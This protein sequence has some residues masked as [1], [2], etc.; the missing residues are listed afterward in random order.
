LV[1]F[2]ALLAFFVGVVFLATA[3][4]FAVVVVG[5]FLAGAEAA[6]FGVVAFAV[7][8]FAGVAFLVSDIPA[9]FLTVLGFLALVATGFFTSV[10]LVAVSVFLEV[11]GRAF[12]INPIHLSSKITKIHTAYL[13]R[14]GRWLVLRCELDFTRG[15]FGESEDT[16]VD[17]TL[18]ST[19]EL[20]QTRSSEVD[21]VF[22]LSELS[23]APTSQ[24]RAR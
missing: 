16:L 13:L 4:F 9:G 1:S 23:H 14:F 18:D 8:G 3:A 22:V 17:T 5:A 7:V 12:Y 24:Q 10:F 20:G 15:A 19:V 6:F 21:L 2:F 11:T